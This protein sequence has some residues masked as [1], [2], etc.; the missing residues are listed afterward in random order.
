[1]AFLFLSGATI[2][3]AMFPNW[4]QH[5]ALFIPAQYLATGLESAVTGMT[6][7][8]EILTD[9]A[10]L[11]MGLLVAF[12][13][14]RQLFRWE[15]EAKAPR[16]AKLWV[17]AALLPFLAFGVWESATGTRLNHI[18]QNFDILSSRSI[19]EHMPGAH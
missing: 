15:P 11:V 18:K 1:M 19:T 8:T 5:V 2:P 3:L 13:V 10:A 7:R 9:T 6:N 14:S 16:S 17:L 4:L 12:E